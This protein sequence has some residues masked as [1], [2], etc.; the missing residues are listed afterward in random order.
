MK[1]IARSP[2]WSRFGRLEFV[3]ER[4]TALLAFAGLL[5]GSPV[6]A[7]SAAPVTPVRLDWARGA[8]ADDCPDARVIA[9]QIRA[10]LGNE[11][12]SAD[13]R[14]TIEAFVT[15]QRGRWVATVVAR[16]DGETT[17]RRSIESAGETCDG[18]ASAAVLA[19]VL[20][21]RPEGPNNASLSSSAASS[22]ASNVGGES[23]SSAGQAS[24]GEPPALPRGLTTSGASAASTGAS[25]ST[26][27]ADSI[28]LQTGPTQ[29]ELARQ[30]ARSSEANV[31]RTIVATALGGGAHYGLTPGWGAHISAVAGVR[32][33]GS[34]EV[35]GSFRYAFATRATTPETVYF[36]SALGAVHGCFQPTTGRALVSLC[37]GLWIG[38]IVPDVR[39]VLSAMTQARWL[40]APSA[41]AEVALRIAGPVRLWAALDAAVPVTRDTFV[42]E[43]A[44]GSGADIKVFSIFYVVP[45]LSLGIRFDFE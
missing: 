10:R 18:I 40:L 42:I 20:A 34:W 31:S 38:A 1:E 15:R 11:S 8:G 4:R 35:R 43:T 12:L 27:A 39:G 26:S 33:A 17:G 30:R 37:A 6:L 22:N 23:G 32:F 29:T 2:D 19:I 45:S 28:A 13:A 16:A 21:I 3:V 9:E 44:E 41:A 5:W 14:R 36:S 24:S 25:V 7:Q